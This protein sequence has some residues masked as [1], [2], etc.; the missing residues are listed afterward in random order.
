MPT[1]NP[2]AL[3]LFGLEI[4]WYGIIM[5]TAM[6]VGVL[7]AMKRAK[8][9]GMSGDTIVDL[10]LIVLPAAILG[11]RLY[12]VAFEWQQY[13]GDLWHILNFREGGLAI[14]GGVIAAI[15]AGIVFTRYKKLPTW[16]LADVA[17]PSVILGQAIGRWGNFINQEAHGGP[18]DL[19]WGIMIEG[20]RVH[21]TFLYES[22]WNLMV[23]SLLLVFEKKKAFEGELMLWYAVLYSM[24]RF[25]IEG[26]RTDSLMIGPI[27]TAQLLSLALIV[28]GSLAIALGRSR[29]R[30]RRAA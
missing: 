26:L 29:T 21:P 4:R 17:A 11:A 13:K 23:F 9:Q 16:T 22:L 6:L 8:K 15:L 28:G 12:Y 25:W 14:H 19:P 1:I 5:A 20:V 27:R 30:K 18:T 24:G 7:L 3:N 2:V 10:A